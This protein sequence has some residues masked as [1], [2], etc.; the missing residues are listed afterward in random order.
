MEQELEMA[1]AYIEAKN[2]EAAFNILHPLSK[3]FI[4]PKQFIFKLLKH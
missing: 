3:F 4:F 2:Y 1:Q